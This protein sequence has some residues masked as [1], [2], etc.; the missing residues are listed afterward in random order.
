[1]SQAMPENRF[2]GLRV[3]VTGYDL[4]QGEH[5]GIAVYTKALIRCLH[6]AGAEVWL[7][8]EFSATL[9]SRGM[10]RLPRSNRS[11]IQNARILEALA[12]GQQV[13]DRNFLAERFGFIRTILKWSHRLHLL[14]EFIQLPKRYER[15]DL[16]HF[17]LLG[18][19]D[20]PYKRIER[21]SYLQHLEGIVSAPGVFLAS[22]TA[23][24]LKQDKPVQIDLQ[25]FD[26]LLTSCP[27][28]ILPHHLPVFVQT[29]HDLIPLE[30]VSHN[31]NS[32]MFSRRLQA[33]LPA[34]RLFVSSSTASKFHHHIRALTKE[35]QRKSGSRPIEEQEQ[36]IVQPP[37]LNFPDWILADPHRIGDLEPTSYLLRPSPRGKKRTR[38]TRAFQYVLFNS[39]VEARKNLLLLAQAYAQSNLSSHGI[40]LWVTGKLK[41]DEYSKSIQEIVRHE[42]GIMLT[43]YVDESTKLDLYLNSL[44][45]LSPSLV[46][47]FGIPVLDAACLGMPSIASDCDSHNEIRSMHD[48]DQH[49]LTISTLQSSDWAEAMNAIAGLGEAFKDP[50][51]ATKE[52]RRRISRYQHYKS[53]F[54]KDLTDKLEAVLN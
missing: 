11:I 5:R 48:F 9:A 26:L 50:K 6:E 29:V 44:A 8:T 53:I 18:L 28:N 40:N 24:L 7:L 3:L 32:L 47:G 37:S 25:D 4:E 33:C 30:Y 34:R 16:H 51:L 35:E 13:K 54:Y 1:M 41:V 15:K 45:L 46:E 20:N 38:S 42:P 19:I 10:R 52:R 49:V 2:N 12:T 23:A 22:Q 21:L 36:V 39:S 17:P 14:I 43:G 27:L 31:E